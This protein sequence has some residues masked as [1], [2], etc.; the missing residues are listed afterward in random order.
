M[1]VSGFLRLCV[2]A[3]VV[4]LGSGAN[5]Q[6]P[7]ELTINDTITLQAGETRIF[8][9]DQSVNQVDIIDPIVEVKPQSDRTFTFHANGAGSTIMTAYKDREVAYRARIVVEGH[10]VKIYGQGRPQ[11]GHDYEIGGY[12]SYLCTRTGCGRANPDV[13]RGPDRVTITEDAKG[14]VQAVQK[15][16]R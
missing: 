12:A 13:V 1:S 5:A 9:F 11:H 4:I 2:I 8:H 15:E 3:T 14:N 10:L 6:P 7:E 16:Y